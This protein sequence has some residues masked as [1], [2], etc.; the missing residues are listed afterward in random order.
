MRSFDTRKSDQLVGLAA[1]VSAFGLWGFIPIYWRRLAEVPASELLAHR[2]VW[3]LPLLALLLPLTGRIRQLGRLRGNRAVWPVLLASTALIATN[4]FTFV[5]AVNAGFLLQASLGYYINPLVNVALGYVFLGERLRR[6]QYGAIAL[7]LVAVLL[8]TLRVGAFPWIAFVLAGT[9]GFYGLLRKTMPVDALVGLSVEMCLLAPIAI[10]FLL[11]RHSGPGTG[12]TGSFAHDAWL[13]AAGPVT[14]LPLLLFTVGA[15][16]LTLATVGITQYLAP[17]G[18]F[19][20]AVL[21]FRET[22]GPVRLLAFVM[23]WVALALYTMDALRH[24][25]RGRRAR[26]AAPS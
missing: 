16:R 12:L 20:I 17:T 10:V 13:Y 2:I 4:W 9:F 6:A 3:A 15:R 22:F 5:Y 21:L 8:L 7:A 18:Q 14:V 19:L 26:R 25:Q 11:L 1:T 23:I 24:A